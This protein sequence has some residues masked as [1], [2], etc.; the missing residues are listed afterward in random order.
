MKQAPSHKQRLGKT[1]ETIASRYLTAK[2]YRIIEKNFRT[3]NGE[4]D[5]IAV[6]N[7]TLVFVEV[8]TRIGHIFGLPEEAV[9]K[10]KFHQIRRVAHLYKSLHPKLPEALRIDVISIEFDHRERKGKLRFFKGVSL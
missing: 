5:L 1:G 10:R 7:D 9:T 6:T 2:G 8:K 4:I 3:H